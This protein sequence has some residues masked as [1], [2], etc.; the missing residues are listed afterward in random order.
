MRISTPTQVR[1]GNTLDVVL[2]LEDAGAFACPGP[3]V[4]DGDTHPLPWRF[5][6][7]SGENAL[8]ID[9]NA[10]GRC[11][12]YL[13]CVRSSS[14]DAPACAPHPPG[15]KRSQGALMRSPSAP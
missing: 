13:R 5:T 12:P 7:P 10:L 2:P 15:T 6:V 8:C 9:I 3:R 4:N 14:R 1:A 11:S